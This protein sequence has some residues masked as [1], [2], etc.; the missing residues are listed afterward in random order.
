M[1]RKLIAGEL[2]CAALLLG[3][4]SAPKLTL[5]SGQW[6]EV[7]QPKVTPPM[8]PASAAPLATSYPGPSVAAF[9]PPVQFGP[10]LGAPAVTTAP[11]PSSPL[12][13]TAVAP[14]SP[15]STPPAPN[16]GAPVVSQV[17]PAPAAP[18]VIPA[19]P[20]KSTALVVAN[21]APAKPVT[22]LPAPKVVPTIA[23]PKV[24]PVAPPKPVATVVAPTAKPLKPV[25]VPKPV[26]E[27]QVGESLR[28]VI[29]RWSKRANYTVD[30]VA[31]DLDYPIDAP[32]RF[33]G[34]FEEAVADIF[35]L[36]EKA[37]RSFVVDGRRKQ[38]R[39]IVLEDGDKTK[40]TLK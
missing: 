2:L 17:S 37:D 14:V 20:V 38:G 24:F 27:A 5:P 21:T 13:P 16:T 6:V 25:P 7:S 34:S 10:S 30:W 31:E 11:M 40:R 18:G 4:S 23:A 19:A 9:R 3:C 22:P 8:P 28:K 36:Y 39:L 12:A 29:E 1:K 33:Q 35:Q 26:W 15:K 32:L